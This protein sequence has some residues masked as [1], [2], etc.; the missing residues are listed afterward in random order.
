M[1]LG[2]ELRPTS[3]AI[4][5]RRKNQGWDDRVRY[6]YFSCPQLEAQSG[7]RGHGVTGSRGHGLKNSTGNEML[8]VSKREFLGELANNIQQHTFSNPQ[9][10]SNHCIRIGHHRLCVRRRSARINVI[11]RYKRRLTVSLRS[12]AKSD[13]W[14]VTTVDLVTVDAFM[15]I[16]KTV[17]PVTQF[18][19]SSPC[20]R[21]RG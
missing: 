20:W 18:A 2:D 1:I 15:V 8:W 3:P 10:Q 16:Y 9:R 5:T 6:D 13:L 21:S 11:Y 4:S 14:L 17:G 12:L 7:G 19:S